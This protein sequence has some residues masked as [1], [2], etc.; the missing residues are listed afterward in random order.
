MGGHERQAGLR[1]RET[2]QE[3][4]SEGG[5]WR[6][7]AYVLQ[8]SHSPYGARLVSVS[9]LTSTPPPTYSHLTS[10][11]NSALPTAWSRSLREGQRAE[12]W[13]H[14]R[15]KTACL[16][17]PRRLPH[18]NLLPSNMIL[19]KNLQYH[20]LLY[21][22]KLLISFSHSR[23]EVPWHFI[24]HSHGKPLH[25]SIWTLLHMGSAAPPTASGTD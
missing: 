8:S 10:A 20:I 3:G 5:C 17:F 23:R 14:S 2:Q 7:P 11:S 9:F 22:K 13:Q 24:P 12:M 16:S 4:S 18:F 1:T 19:C 15:G 25:T 21:E 6:G